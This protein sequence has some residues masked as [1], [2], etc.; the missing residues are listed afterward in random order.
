MKDYN[1]YIAG[2]TKFEI[3]K[4][5]IESGKNVIFNGFLKQKKLRNFKLT[6]IYY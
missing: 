4:L 6:W 3:E 2:G 1:F 5:K